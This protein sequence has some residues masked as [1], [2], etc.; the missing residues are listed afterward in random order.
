MDKIYTGIGSRTT[1]TEVL[2]IMLALA[3]TLN[4]E[5]YILRSGAAVGADSAF[6][7][8]SYLSQAEIYLPWEGFNGS[9]STF[10]PP[11]PEA[12]EIAEKYHP[13]FKNLKSPVKALHARNVHQILG[14]NITNDPITSF[15]VCWTPDGCE[16][17]SKTTKFT[18]GTGQALRIAS[19]YNVPIFNLKN[20]GSFE[21][22]LAFIP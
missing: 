17:G 3:G 13:S 5:G 9:K 14:W 19:A 8:G 18:G 4:A 6:E 2:K 1:P 20:K 22:L 12:Y 21:K 16:D 11:K 10:Y 7:L 15:V